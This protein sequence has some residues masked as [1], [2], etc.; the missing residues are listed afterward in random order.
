MA[1]RDG[2]TLVR[3]E[4]AFTVLLAVGISGF[5][6]YTAA[7]GTLETLLQRV[8]HLASLLA[9]TFLIKPLLPGRAGLPARLPDYAMALASLAMGA[10]VLLG[11]ERI[12]TRAPWMDPV[13]PWDVFFAVLTTLFL[14]EA[15]R[16]IVGGVMATVVAAF[17]GYA[18]LGPF[19]P[20]VLRHDRTAFLE[21]VD[22]LFLTTEGIFG[23]PIAASA[24]F[25]FLFVLFGAFLEATKVGEFIIDFA[26]ALVGRARGGPAK[27]AV[28]A[29]ACFGTVSG[30]SVANVYGTGI[31]TIPLMKRIGYKPHFAGAV[32]AAAS[33]GGQLMPPV[34]GS[35]AFII[36]ETLNIDYLQVCVAAIIPS[37]LYFYSIGLATHLE[38]A[39]GG[40]P[41]IGAEEVAR[42]RRSLLRRLH[43]FLPPAIL[44]VFL[45]LRFSPYY[46]ALWSIVG[47]VLVSYLRRDTALGPRGFL[48]AMEQGARSGAMIAVATAAAGIIVGVVAH[49]GLGFKF[50][51]L[52]LGLAKGH[53]FYALFFTMIAAT[54]LGMGVPT[55]PAYIIVSVIAAP[56]LIEL[57][58]QPLVAHMYVFMFAILSAVTPPVAVAGYAGANIAE[59]DAMK[60]SFTA[61]KLALIGF[62]IPY[63]AVYNPSLLAQGELPVI[64]RVTATALAGVTILGCGM[65]GW[66]RGRLGVPARVCL[67]VGGLG[68][69]DPNLWTDLLGLGV[70]AGGMLWEVAARRR[71]GAPRKV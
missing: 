40:L 1:D 64:L 67:V 21:L 52:V 4:R 29:S 16:R 56:S 55:T 41:G 31:F 37:L 36:A 47:T 30:A 49:T 9:L 14:L 2:R 44:V 25:V 53:L 50:M 10:Y 65:Y 46:A 43:L 51:T 34:M 13:L 45:V 58:I 60:T 63:M 22:T 23:I 42:A 61:W 48:S 19:L 66:L 20:G 59:A 57:H 17:L 71:A 7:F 35:A 3:I 15:A 11:H 26:V 62:V 24:T 28:M 5:H 68:M 8:V 32:E 18:F 6:L 69:I 70:I 39:R 54:I 12:S 33:T 27:V 38:A